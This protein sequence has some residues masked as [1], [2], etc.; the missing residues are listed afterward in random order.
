MSKRKPLLALFMFI[1]LLF[2]CQ[3]DSED[4]TMLASEKTLPNNFEEIAYK[5]GT[6]TI[7]ARKAAD[8]AAFDKNWRLYELE[9]EQ[10]D[11]DFNEHDVFF[12]GVYESGSCASEITRV[13]LNE[14]RTSMTL[15]ISGPDGA[16]ACT[17][18]ATPR[19]FVIQLEKKLIENVKDLVIEETNVPFE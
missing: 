4:F 9:Q 14:D 17:S 7:L 2:G 3:S 5:Y 12:I 16:K 13:E 1:S 8:Q 19:T 15:P 11:V 6:E 10:P 18:N